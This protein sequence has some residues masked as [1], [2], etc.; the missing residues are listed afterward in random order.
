MT[1]IESFKD[2]AVPAAILL[3]A[4]DWGFGH[5][6]MDEDS[7][8]VFEQKLSNVSAKVDKAV[9]LGQLFSMM[10]QI[11]YPATKFAKILS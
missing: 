3:N 10:Q 9:I 8:K 1:V 6:H 4:D 2:K 5:F 11:E 7:V